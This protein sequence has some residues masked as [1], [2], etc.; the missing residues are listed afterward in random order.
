MATEEE[1]IRAR[2]GLVR[3]AQRLGLPT[4]FGEL[5]CGQLR[6][7]QAMDRMRTYLLGVRP[8]RM[9]EIA[10]EMLA[11]MQERDRW[12]EQKRSEEANASITRFYNRPRE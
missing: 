9:E 2:E 10:D 12:I 5:M 4:E 1:R 11:I 6:T 7:A 8:T 3:A